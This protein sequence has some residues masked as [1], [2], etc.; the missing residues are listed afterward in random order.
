MF[1]WET[2]G[3]CREIRRFPLALSHWFLVWLILRP[4]KWRQRVR[5]KR[6]LTF[7]G[8]VPQNIQH[9]IYYLVHEELQYP[10]YDMR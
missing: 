7:N 8:V 5:P 2:G 6:R 10:I 1:V 3:N 9:F 4:R